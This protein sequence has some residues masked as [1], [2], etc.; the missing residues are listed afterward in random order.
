MPLWVEKLKQEGMTEEQIKEVIDGKTQKYIQKWG[1]KSRVG[2]LLSNYND[3]I[4]QKKKLDVRQPKTTRA[5]H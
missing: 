2:I 3:E 1:N 5:I 4:T